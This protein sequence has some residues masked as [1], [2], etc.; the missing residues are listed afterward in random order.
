M[1]LYL[2][3][4]QPSTDCLKELVT[5]IV[6]FNQKEFFRVFEQNTEKASKVVYSSES[7]EIDRAVQ[8]VNII[9]AILKSEELE[10]ELRNCLGL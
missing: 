6:T 9:L 2:N 4:P 10:Q 3:I 5:K 7:K 8:I 1:E